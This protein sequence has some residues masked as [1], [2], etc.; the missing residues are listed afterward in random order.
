MFGVVCVC[1]CFNAGCWCA[2]DVVCLGVFVFVCWCLFLCLM[3]VVRR[4]VFDD[5][6]VFICVC[7]CGVPC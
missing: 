1:V 5:G 3:F 7:G 4:V 2:F 6:C